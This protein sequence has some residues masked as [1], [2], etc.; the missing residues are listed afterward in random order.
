MSKEKKQWKVSPGAYGFT[1]S[2]DGEH[3]IFISA[4][5]HQGGGTCYGIMIA[6]VDG[7]MHVKKGEVRGWDPKVVSDAINK[8]VN[9]MLKAAG[10]LSG[11]RFEDQINS[12]VAYLLREQ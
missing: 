11:N 3:E 9:R 4:S 10:W 1:L 2:D 12:A 7:G 6:I 8:D 5:G